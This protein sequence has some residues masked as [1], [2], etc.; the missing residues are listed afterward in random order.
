[1][2]LERTQLYVFGSVA[3]NWMHYPTGGDTVDWIT[4]SCAEMGMRGDD[5]RLSSVTIQLTGRCRRTSPCRA[6]RSNPGI[7]MQQGAANQCLE[8]ARLP[9]T[10]SS[11]AEF[12]GNAGIRRQPQRHHYAFSAQFRKLT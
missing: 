12:T 6:E 5:R 3:P 9:T 10:G 11:G 7:Q 8:D 2:I 1:M 4:L